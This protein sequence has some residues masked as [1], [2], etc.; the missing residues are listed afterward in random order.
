M[1][2]PL[3]SW[4]ANL[5]TT[6]AAFLVSCAI[7]GMAFAFEPPS[8]EELER[9][10]VERQAMID[11]DPP[12]GELV[13]VDLSI[14]A[15]GTTA[16]LYQIA[17]TLEVLGQSGRD[18]RPA[19]LRH[20]RKAEMAVRAA[21]DA[22]GQEPDTGVII[23][24]LHKAAKRLHAAAPPKHPNGQRLQDI[25]RQLA[26][27][28]EAIAGDMVDLAMF[29]GLD[30]GRQRALEVRFSM[31]QRFLRAELYSVAIGIFGGAASFVS[32]EVLS[33]DIDLFEQN[34]RDALDNQTVGYAYS[35]GLNGERYINNIDDHGGLARTS[36]DSPETDQSATKEM[37]IASI[38]KTISTVAMLKALAEAG[39]SVDASIAPYLPTGWDQGINMSGTAISDITFRHLMTH[40]SGLAESG[41]QTLVELEQAIAAGSSGIVSFE[42]A[43]YI[44]TNFS[45]LR[46]LVPQVL[47]GQDIIDVYTGIL[48]ADQVYAGLFEQYVSVNVLAPAGINAPACAPREGAS[49]RTLYYLFGAP[50]SDAGLDLGDWGLRC[51]ATGYYLSAVELGALLAYMRYTDEIIDDSIRDLMNTGYLGWLNPVR[52]AGFIVSPDADGDWGIYRAHGGDSANGNVRGMT[53]CMMNYPINVE[54]VVLINSRG[55]NISGHACRVL[56]DAYDDAWVVN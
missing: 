18:F 17:S 47:V 5:F 21:L 16:T 27:A 37:Y 56:R 51:G 28:A 24:Y 44:N 22:Y 31:A 30:G 7:S 3:S 32:N 9:Q 52:F 6:A 38:T 25:S 40:R 34:I 55:N 54:A 29:A 41:N 43:P 45:L 35:I 8:L 33:F 11:A 15:T 19:A 2:K 10:L 12:R 36:A 26:L 1:D 20:I 14:G 39:I 50:T 13:S 23:R 46:V 53:S 42:N 49:S 48:P 4:S